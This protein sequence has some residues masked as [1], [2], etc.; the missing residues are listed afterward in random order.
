MAPAPSM[1]AADTPTR[2]AIRV[3][4]TVLVA[5]I[6]PSRGG[7]SAVNHDH[8]AQRD[9]ALPR[10]DA[11]PPSGHLGK[12]AHEEVLGVARRQVDAAV[13]DGN[14][15]ALVPERRVKRDAPEEVLD[16]GDVVESVAALT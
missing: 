10:V 16:V 15:E 13:A 1:T 5:L 4:R 8:R 7:K 12:R 6:S 2:S 11:V 14:A 9:A 3:I